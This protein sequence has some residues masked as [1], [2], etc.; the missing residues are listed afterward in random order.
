V[1]KV[2]AQH[3]DAGQFHLETRYAVSEHWEWLVI[4]MKGGS[5]RFSGE[6]RTLESAKHSAETAIGFIGG[7]RWTDIGPPIELED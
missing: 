3:A 6:E 5:A 4:S 1:R 7:A 2:S